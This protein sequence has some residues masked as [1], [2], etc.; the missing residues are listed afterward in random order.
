MSIRHPAHAGAQ[1]GAPGAA[2]FWA[3]RGVQGLL[4]GAVIATLDFLYYFPLVSMPNEIGFGAYGS[5]LVAWC[6]QGALFALALGAAERRA[7]PRGLR[8]WQLGLAI[9]MTVAASVILWQAFTAFVVRD[10]LGIRLFRD[11]VGQPGHWLGAVLYHAWLMLFFGG[12]VAAVGASQRARTRML[13]ELRAAQL[14]QAT[15]RQRLTE[16][17]LASLEARIDPDHLYHTLSRLE[18]LYEDDPPAADRVLDDLIVF[19]RNALAG[20]RAV[21]PTS[22]A[23]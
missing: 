8:A 12:L 11:Y 1:A 10:Q 9:V 22:E 5:S 18:G 16:A 23:P 2:R 3:A 13:A 17:R 21:P 19:L 4:V 7:G 15:S 6:G 20:A 14:G